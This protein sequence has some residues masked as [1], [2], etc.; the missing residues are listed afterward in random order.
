MILDEKRNPFRAEEMNRIS[1]A[2]D[3]VVRIEEIRA[4][5]STREEA[6]KA[7]QPAAQ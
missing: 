5:A 1:F 7:A 2:N 3:V 6:R 4:E